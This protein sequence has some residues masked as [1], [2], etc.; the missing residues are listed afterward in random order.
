MSQSTVSIVIPCYNGEQFI[1]HS[2]RSVWEQDYPH[3]ELI[4]VN[5]GSED[6]TG[7]RILAWKQS[8][9]DKG[10]ELKY[11][12]QESLSEF[13][14]VYCDPHSQRLWCSQ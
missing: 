1:D 14:T 12:Y 2:I 6:R 9:A 7:E 10:W 5:D 11:L 13:S 8:F 4:V 3:V